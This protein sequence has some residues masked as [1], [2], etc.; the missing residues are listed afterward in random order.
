[1]L[2]VMKYIY[3]PDI[4]RKIKCFFIV[5]FLIGAITPFFEIAR[6]VRETSLCIRRG[7]ICERRYSM[8]DSI[9]DKKLIGPNFLGKQE[10]L[11]NK[12]LMK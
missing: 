7:E 1:M 4:N 10:S 5:V 9:F 2:L 12:Y 3:M 11:F 8:D 6:T